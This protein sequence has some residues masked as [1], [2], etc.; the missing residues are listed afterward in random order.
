MLSSFRKALNYLT[1]YRFKIA[2]NIV[3]NVLT[4][5][6]EVVSLVS[7]I[8]FL[9]LL[10][11]KDSAIGR[12]TKPDPISFSPIKEG[13]TGVKD[14]LAYQFQHFVQSNSKLEALTYI[15]VTVLIIFF[16]KNILFYIGRLIDANIRYSV[17][18]D[19][20]RSMYK[21]VLELPVGYF[22]EQR[23]GDIISRFSADIGKLEI[24]VLNAYK[25]L[26]NNPVMILFFLISM[27]VL[28]SKLTLF[29]LILL[30]V[31]GLVVGKIS[32][33]LK[34][35]SVK[36]M[37]KLGQIVSTLDETLFG[38]KV[39]KA[40]TAEDYLADKFDES[41]HELYRLDN[42]IAKR[43][44]AAGPVS[45][46]IGI[47][48]VTLV[49]WFGGRLILKDEQALTG[50]SFIAFILLFARLLTPVKDLSKL[51][52][53]MLEALASGDR[54]NEV[55]N[56]VNPISDSTD[57]IIKEEF[58]SSIEFKNVGFSYLKNNPVL[59]DLNFTLK[60]GETAALVGQ[61]GAGKSTIADL[62]PRFFDIDEGEILIDGVDIKNMSLKS[63]R[64]LISF[65]SQDSILFNDSVVNNITFGQRN[66]DLNDVIHAA[67]VANAH[68]FIEQL[69][70]GYDT[71]I[72]ERG[73]KLSGGQKQRLTIARAVF[74]NAP[75][76]IMDEATSAL[77]TESEKLVQEAINNLLK[78]KTALVI[79]H[80]LSTIRNADKIYV[81]K[82]GSIV[83]K[84]THNSLMQLE[85]GK[86]RNL[87]ELQSV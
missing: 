19:L 20:R 59:K 44:D 14:H 81:I 23:R 15:C 34:R 5:F 85:K 69:E 76:L 18:R 62:I 24:N 58:D 48:V 42:K 74:R 39:V 45:E 31:L 13:I 52:A 86:Y 56:T 71:H 54:I 7:I 82:D 40:Y 43:R 50:A 60:K 26:F 51:Y 84:G 16:L 9:E 21:K 36:A 11:L 64:N 33:S 75:I 38:A 87:F 35:Q 72:G 1:N 83:E 8:P 73:N 32:K 37:E 6:L 65:V 28:S 49:L 41:T 10:F 80:R 55:I 27:I 70:N 63:M 17:S 3:I 67:R 79:A 12:L 2:M 61:S 53:G 68:E 4:S 46:V 57:S 25:M 22:T 77:D 29:I 47:A 66:Y 30:P 78:N